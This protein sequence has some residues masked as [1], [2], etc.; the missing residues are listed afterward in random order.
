M[1]KRILLA[2]DDAAVREMLGRVLELE[3]YEVVPAKSGRAAAMKFLLDPPDLVL[4]D[5]EMPD[6]DGWEAFDSMNQAHPWVPVIAITAKPQQ[7]EHAAALGFD[8]LMEKPLN[9]PL[10]LDAIA[11]L[12]GESVPNRLLRLTHPDFKTLLLN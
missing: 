12:L 11:E 5:L 2:D 10:L 6:K 7:Y 4:L 3:Q 1:K 8:A 9:L